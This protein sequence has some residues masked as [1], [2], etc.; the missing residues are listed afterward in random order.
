ME[1][2]GSP[3]MLMVILNLQNL[4][5]NDNLNTAPKLQ[6]ALIVAEVYLSALPMD[7]PYQN[8]ELR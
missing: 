4:M 8:F 2:H 3:S 5:I 1:K 7:T 6:M